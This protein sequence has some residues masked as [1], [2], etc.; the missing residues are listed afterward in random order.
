MEYNATTEFYSRLTTVFH[1]KNYLFHFVLA[2]IVSQDYVLHM[3]SLTDIDRVMCLLEN[4]SAPLE[5]GE[6]QNFYKMLEIMQ[7]HGN[8]HAQQLVEDIKACIRREDPVVKNKT[9]EAIASSIEGI[10]I[11]AT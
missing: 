4:V 11:I 7:T 6:K 1:D 8:L 5:S 3:Y 2:G 9:T 10:Y